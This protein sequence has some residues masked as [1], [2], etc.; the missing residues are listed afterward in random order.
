MVVLVAVVAVEPEASQLLF[1]AVVAVEPE[2]SQLVFVAAVSAEPQ[3][4]E[5]VFVAAVSAEPEASEP[6]FVAAV[7][8]EPQA[9]EP[10]FVALEPLDVS[11]PQVSVDIAVVFVALIPAFVVAIEVDIPGFPRIFVHH[12]I[13]SFANL[14]S[15]VEIVDKESVHS[16]TGVHSN[17]GFCSI[18]SNLDLHH[19]KNLEHRYN[20]PSPGHN[21]LSDT[22]DLPIDATKNHSRNTGL[23]RSQGMHTHRS[24]QASLSHLEVQQIR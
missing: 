2:A 8:A 21:K 22:N 12:K 7:S 20:N 17:Y 1:V 10:V 11:E 3:A 14:S 4:S 15:S 18:L 16:S 5:P 6:V 23:H 13:C 9:S 19:N 24:S